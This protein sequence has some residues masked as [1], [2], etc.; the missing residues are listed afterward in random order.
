MDRRFLRTEAIL[1]KESMDRLKKAKVA[2][3]GI[4][5]V[6]TYAVETLVRSGI[7][8]IVLVDY[9]SIDITNINRQI[10]ALESTLGKNKVDIMEE[11]IL[12]INPQAQV[13]KY[14]LKYSEENKNEFNF[15]EYDYIIDAIDTIASK[16]SLIEMAYKSGVPIISAMGAG[17]KLDPTRVMVSDIYKTRI[18]PLARVMRRE[19]RRRHIDRLKV[20]WSDEE[21]ISIHLGDKD[22]RKAT[23]A[24]LV[25][26][27]GVVGMTIGYE[28]LKDIMEEGV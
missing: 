17:N 13:E 19:L 22:K 20:V 21:P 7:G 5:G 24:S 12:D 18:C 9:D 14:R 10:I 2:I 1:G 3:F 26:V 15:L 23:P 25:F 27:P 28:V 8:N 6:G 16:L 4:G 11:R